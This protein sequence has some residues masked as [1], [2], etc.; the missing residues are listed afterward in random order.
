MLETLVRLGLPTAGYTGVSE[1]TTGD[2]SQ[3]I[4]KAIV[5]VNEEGTVAAAVSGVAMPAS[6][7]PSF[8]VNRPFFF[9]IQDS[10]TGAIL[11]MGAIYDPE[12][13][14]E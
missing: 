12:P 8:V 2:I 14:D 11:F 13:L 3:V 10:E 7:P 9:T 1:S 5:K 4:H 6:M